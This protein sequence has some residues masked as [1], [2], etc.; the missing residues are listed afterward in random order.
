VVAHAIDCDVLATLEDQPERWIDLRWHEG[1]HPPV[2]TV[3][4]D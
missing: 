1:R 2:Y 3:A 4:L